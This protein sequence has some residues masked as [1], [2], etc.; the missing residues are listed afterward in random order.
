[1]ELVIAFAIAFVL[2]FVFG[3]V[4]RERYAKKIVSSMLDDLE[5]DMVNTIKENTIP[6]KIEKHGEA[7]YV[8][9]SESDEFMGQGMTRDELEKELA[10]RFPNKKFNATSENLKEVGFI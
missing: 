7:L 1:M 9:N 10:K 4:Q 3:W 5:T 8:F 6:I 2:G